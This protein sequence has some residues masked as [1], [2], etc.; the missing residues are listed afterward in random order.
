MTQYLLSVWGTHSETG[1][2][3][4]AGEGAMR[5]AFEQV[6]A[7]NEGLVASGRMIFAC[8]LEAPETAFVAYAGEQGVDLRPGIL[9]QPP[10][11]GGFWVVEA[12]DL[13]AAQQLAGEAS[14]ACGNAVEMRPLSG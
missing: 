9:G 7:F 2:G 13:A 1:T 8:G 6:A 11:L 4:Y 14:A 5:A 10:A 3:P 12:P